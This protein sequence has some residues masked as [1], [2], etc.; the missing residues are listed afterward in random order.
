MKLREQLLTAHTKANCDLIVKWVGKNQ[1]R[2][3]QL[4]ELFLKDEYRVVQRA[5]WP[6]SYCVIQHPPFIK[7]HFGRMVKNL[8]KPGIIDAVKRNTLRLLQHIP[9]PKR[10]QGQVM[11]LCFT[12]LARPG[13]AIA[14]KAFSLTVL[15]HLVALY[16]EILPEIKLLIE[17]N[18]DHATPAFKQRAK[19]L[20]KNTSAT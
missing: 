6:L 14:I 16:P 11:D 18:Y 4:F 9:I 7:K 10:Y 12:Y 17:E 13:E 8:H 3:D 5:A 19:Q 2:F 1:A 15:E 20:L